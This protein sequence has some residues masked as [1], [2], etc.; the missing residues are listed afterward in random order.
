LK[1]VIVTPAAARSR[2]GNRN[3]AWRWAGFLRELGHTVELAQ[4][5]SGT[6]AD[7]MIALHARRSHTSIAAYAEAFP[8]R[9][10]IVALTGTDLYRDIKVDASAQESLELATRL[11]VLQEL[12]VKELPPRLRPR[13]RT[14]YQSARAVLP[15][16][17]L[18]SCFEVVV[19][20]HL[21]E[22]KDPFRAAAA[23][24]HLPPTSRVRVTHIGGALTPAFAAE[25]RAWMAR[26][27]RYRWL[28]E[29]PRWKALR[30]LA[31]SRVMILSSRMEGGANVVS[32]A[33]AA[34]VPVIAARVR[35]NV[36]MLGASYSGYYPVGDERALARL[37]ARTEGD[38]AYRNALER[39]CRARAPLVAPRRER[40]AL[41]ALVT[42]AAEAAP[43]RRRSRA[44]AA[45]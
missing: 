4:S 14:I 17:P 13:V 16:A 31:R 38:S 5:W 3:T 12:G 11:V 44:R 37:I 2:S 20:G 43:V 18:A 35:G 42:E 26:E 36:G 8:D 24:A 39:L 33:L 9:P 10:L 34:G 40:D 27:P 19:S 25:A 6:N 23:L 41:K 30:V 22:E 29:L 28:G 45:A 21:R 7:L 1:I 32:E 15:P